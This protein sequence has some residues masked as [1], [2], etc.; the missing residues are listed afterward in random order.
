MRLRRY[1]EEKT[2]ASSTVVI[3]GLAVHTDALWKPSFAE[4]FNANEPDFVRVFQD[5]PDTALHI[6]R[7]SESI[8]LAASADVGQ[9]A[10]LAIE[11]PAT[12]RSQLVP[13]HIL[14]LSSALESSHPLQFYAR[15][16]LRHG[17]DT[18]VITRALPNSAP[19]C[20]ADFDLA[21]TGV[22]SRP[23][24]HLWLDLIFENPSSATVTLSDV[25]ISLHPR[26]EC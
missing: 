23:L 26:A 19:T 17:P 15:L 22:G 24:Q 3:D 13:R 14:R 7:K 4:C 21:T 8:A 20:T 10:S 2:I 16:N 5:G 11:V 9:F 25:A 6:T 12:L 1:K 18:D